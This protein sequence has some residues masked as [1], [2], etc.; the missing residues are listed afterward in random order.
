MQY[1][2][3][4]TGKL[5]NTI[6]ST[7]HQVETWS[8]V[9]RKNTERPAR[10][11]GLRSGAIVA[12]DADVFLQ[13]GERELIEIRKRNPGQIVR[14]QSHCKIRNIRVSLI[15][16]SAKTN[17]T[18]HRLFWFEGLLTSHLKFQIASTT[19]FNQYESL[20]RYLISLITISGPR[21]NL[22]PAFLRD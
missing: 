12:V 11:H 9:S 13:P 16:L 2:G 18:I 15:L 7:L 20:N 22:N 14:L 21:M 6:E 19:S 1:T 3:R 10:I 17:K 5:D 4:Q 8:Y